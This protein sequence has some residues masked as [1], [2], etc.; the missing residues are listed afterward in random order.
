[1]LCL[2]V[3][4]LLL[5]LCSPL[6]FVVRCCEGVL[7]DVCILWCVVVRRLMFV[8]CLLWLVCFLCVVGCLTLV[9][10]CC[11]LFLL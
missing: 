5:V 7:F 9:V 3:L 10:C 1:M 4:L 11:S 8:V 2:F 6:L